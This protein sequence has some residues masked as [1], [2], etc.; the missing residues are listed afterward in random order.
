MCEILPFPFGAQ[1]ENKALELCFLL[2]QLD[3]QVL[4]FHAMKSQTGD[5]TIP[6]LH[7]FA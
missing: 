6:F 2:N 1:P 3:L 4:E 5:K 7:S